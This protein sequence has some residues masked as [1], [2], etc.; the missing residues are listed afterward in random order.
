MTTPLNCIITVLGT[1]AMPRSA[2][3][4]RASGLARGPSRR[5]D[6]PPGKTADGAGL[7]PL[8]GGFGHG[9]GAAVSTKLALAALL[10]VAHH[11]H[12]RE[13]RRRR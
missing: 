13:K 6:V 9:S 5:D 3:A 11:T 10:L 8:R 1:A 7:T 12:R 4:A 2:C